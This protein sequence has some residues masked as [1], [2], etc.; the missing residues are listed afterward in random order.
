QLQLQQPTT[1]ISDRSKR[2]S[3]SSSQ[4]PIKLQRFLIE[5]E[6]LTVNIGESIILPCRVSNKAGT[7]QCD[8]SLKISSVTLEDDATFQCQV[9]ALDNVPGIRSQSARLT[10]R[11]RPDDPVIV[12]GNLVPYHQLNYNMQQQEVQVLSTTA[13]NKIELT[14]ESHGGRPAAEVR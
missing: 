12:L 6:N 10:V 9:G 13:G 3:S 8:Y 11:V 5:P 4:S 1:I 2:Q 7:V 14:C